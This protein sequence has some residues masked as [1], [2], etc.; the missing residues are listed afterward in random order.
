VQEGVKGSAHDPSVTPFDIRSVAGRG[1][2]SLSR[3]SLSRSWLLHAAT[4]G[5]VGL[6][7]LVVNMAVLWLL[8]DHLHYLLAAV[9]ATEA[10]TT[11]LFVLAEA[12]V[13]RGAKPGTTAARAARFF[14][15]NHAL[16][17]LRLPVLALLVDGIGLNV[18]PA[19]MVTLGLLFVVRLLVADLAIYRRGESVPD[20]G[21]SPAS[22]SSLVSPR[23]P[24]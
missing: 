19:N 2:I 5:L 24:P 18:L 3:T 12:V 14:L 7:G 23:M 8:Y 21:S 9:L 22:A 6:S 17:A 16:L 4:F 11:W 10:S 1:R 15:L 20:T 13:Y